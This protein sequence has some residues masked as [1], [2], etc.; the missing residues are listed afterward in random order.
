LGIT[1]AVGKQFQHP[2]GWFGRTVAR[3]MTRMTAPSVAW[4]IDLLAVEATDEILEV[5]FSGGDGIEKLAA[6]ARN[7]HVIG[8]DVSKTMLAAAAKRNTAAIANGRVELVRAPGGTLP[9]EDGRFDKACTINTAY[10]LESPGDV[11]TEMFRVLKPGGRAAVEFPERERFMQFR[12]LRGPGF[13]FHQLED[14]RAAFETAGFTAVE[15]HAD[16]DLKFGAIC[17]VGTKP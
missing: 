14:L 11:F 12:L 3:V 2:R 9:F 16:P 1:S 5:G 17:L 8:V 13:H 7:G 4:T 15:H 6:R 10:V